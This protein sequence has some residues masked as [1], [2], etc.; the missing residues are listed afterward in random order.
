MMRARLATDV[1][2]RPVCGD[3]GTPERGQ[4][5]LTIFVDGRSSGGFSPSIHESQRHLD[6][7][8]HPRPTDMGPERAHINLRSCDAILG[9]FANNRSDVDR[10]DGTLRSDKPNRLRGDRSVGRTRERHAPE[11]GISRAVRG[12]ENPFGGRDESRWRF[13]QAHDALVGDGG[14]D[15]LLLFRSRHGSNLLARTGTWSWWWA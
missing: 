2:V 3:G 14:P 10:I 5:F 8:R 9:R 13:T 7:A 1:I 12:V 15:R 6:G 4:P 11:G